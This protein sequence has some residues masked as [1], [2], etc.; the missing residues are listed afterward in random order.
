M[1][2]EFNVNEYWL[3]RGRTYVGE[4]LPQEYH[5]VQERFFFDVL[6]GARIPMDRVLELGCGFGR[7]TRLLAEN[8]PRARITALDLSLD[9]LQNARRYCGRNDNVT[10]QEYDFYSDLPLPAGDYD[11][12][13]AV[14]VFL[15]HPA[16][17]VRAVLN[18]LKRTSRYIVNIDWS[19]EWV[20]Q[21]PEHVWVHDYGAVYRELG[22]KCAALPLPQKIEGMQQRLFIAGA[23]LTPE[24]L[25]IEQR[26]REVAA[27]APP[28]QKPPAELSSAAQWLR[29]LK[30]AIEEIRRTI[31]EGST[32]ILVNENQWGG[33]G[34]ALPG[35]RLLPFLE[36]DGQYW[37]PPADD[38]TA[39]RELERMREAGATH[40]VFV[41][42]C[43]WWLEHYSGL[44]RHLQNFPCVLQNQWLVAFKLTL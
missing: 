41:W 36:R 6:R 1:S 16:L 32:I 15:H 12:A 23:E 14:E 19:E 22:L 25:V 26:V 38:A 44:H 3:K 13:I 7:I 8:F 28:E 9:Q 2:G 11:A 24:L 5:R 20:W 37:G 43:F 27:D 29:D 4:R 18:K 35:R 39:I 21:T 33:D 10:F 30:L 34:S 40:I 17:V 31:P 42:S